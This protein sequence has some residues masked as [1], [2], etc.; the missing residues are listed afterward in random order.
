MCRNLHKR[1]SFLLYH[2]V[3]GVHSDPDPV[4]SER[5]LPLQIGLVGDLVGFFILA[6]PGYGSLTLFLYVS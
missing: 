2:Y 5:D 6:A 3:Y 4:I 1:A